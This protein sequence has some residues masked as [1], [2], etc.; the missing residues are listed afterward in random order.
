MHVELNFEK[1]AAGF[2]EHV[3]NNIAGKIIGSDIAIFEVS[4]HNPNVMI[5]LGV[6]LTWGIRVM[7]LR[8]IN[9][10]DIPSDISGQTWIAYEN[11]GKNLADTD[12]QQ[13]LDVMV[14][15]AIRKK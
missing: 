11:S 8:E 1:L 4:N 12:F 10:P 14:E 13:N 7:P 2:G 6:A 15:R 5:E 3:F 9:S